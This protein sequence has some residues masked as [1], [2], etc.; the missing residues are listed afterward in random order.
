MAS[1]KQRGNSYTVTISKGRDINGRKITESR[2]FHPDPQKT[3]KQNQKAL[4]QFAAD[5]ERKVKDGRTAGDN[6]TFEAFARNW[7]EN[8]VSEELKPTTIESYSR[9]LKNWIFPR[10]GHMKVSDIKPSTIQSVLNAMRRNGYK[11]VNKKGTIRQGAYSER[12][13]KDCQRT[14]S[15]VLTAAEID[16]LI[17]RNP[18]SLVRSRKNKNKEE[19]KL[20]AWTAEQAGLFLNKLQEPLPVKVE[21][22]IHHRRGKEIIVK[23][24]TMKTITVSTK[25]LAFFSLAFFSGCRRGEIL[26]LTWRD[27]DFEEKTINIDKATN[28]VSGIGLYTDSPKTATS[29][30]KIIVPC[31]CLTALKRW[32]NEQARNII[33]LGTAWTGD[34]QQKTGLV[35]TNETG[36]QLATA[37]P[38]HYF[39]EYLKLVNNTL[40]SEQRLPH[41]RIHDTRHTSA[42]LL[43]AAGLD[44]VTVARRLGHSDATTTLRIYAHAFQESDRAAADVLEKALSFD[45]STQAI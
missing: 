33:A 38:G 35:F 8:Y 31:A 18:A 37:A 24:Y 13:I 25:W 45:K 29:Y 36:G 21:D 20:N 2:T 27:I 9:A 32:K 6:V 43:I 19:T 16:G 10:I 23:G 12:T 15:A 7:L 44:P 4:A 17:A 28:Y 11:Y 40:P 41:I 39:K 1:I 5:F 3:D 14:I 34:R 26:A 22:K 42:S 30:R